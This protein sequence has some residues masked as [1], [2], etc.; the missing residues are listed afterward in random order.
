[1]KDFGTSNSPPVVGFLLYD[2][3]ADVYFETC[4]KIGGM[5]CTIWSKDEFEAKRYH[6]VQKALNAK[7]DIERDGHERKLEVR[8]LYN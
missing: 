3:A 2:Q 1:M 5:G 4:I 8:M 7:K 6:D